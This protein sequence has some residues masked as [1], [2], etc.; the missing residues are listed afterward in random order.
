MI[1]CSLHAAT[2]RLKLS[3][4]PTGAAMLVRLFKCRNCGSIGGHVSRP[5]TFGERYILPLLFLRPVRCG[6]CGTDISGAGSSWCRSAGDLILSARMRKDRPSRKTHALCAHTRT[7][8][9]G[10]SVNLDIAEVNGFP[11]AGRRSQTAPSHF[12]KKQLRGG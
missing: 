4:L 2:V 8:P 7:A 6:H 10:S 12:S 11:E 1:S 5:R 9:F 3:A